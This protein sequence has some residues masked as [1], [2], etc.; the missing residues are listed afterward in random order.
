M[1]KSKLD[2]GQEC[3]HQTVLQEGDFGGVDTLVCDELGYIECPLVENVL[4]DLLSS[5]RVKIAI[6]RL[7]DRLF[8]YNLLIVAVLCHVLENSQQTES[9]LEVV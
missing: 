5:V 9:L 2:P 8:D 3:V 7:L 6:E 1:W 4:E